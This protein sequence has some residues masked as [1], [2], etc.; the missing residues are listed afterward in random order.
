MKQVY[1]TIIVFLLT[2][3]ISSGQAIK[4]SCS[5]KERKNPEGNDPILVKTCFIKN[6]KFVETSHP[7][8][9]G[10]YV[11]HEYEVYVKKDNKYIRTTNSNVFN[12]NQNKLLDTINTRILEDFNSFRSDSSSNEC[13]T[14]IDTIPTYKMDDINITFSDDKICFVV[15]WGLPMACRDVDGTIISFKIDDIKH[16]LK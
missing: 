5:E 14:G 8:Y 16:Y 6:F 3:S 1:T 13:F 7:D 15:N 12:K 10:R 9:A 4:L 11:F 2:V